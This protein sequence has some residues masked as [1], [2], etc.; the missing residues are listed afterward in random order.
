MGGWCRGII[1]YLTRHRRDTLPPLPLVDCL[2][3]FKPKDILQILYR[4]IC[5][6]TQRF[7][8]F[9]GFLIY[10]KSHSDNH[11]QIVML[12]VVIFTVSGSY[13]VILYN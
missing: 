6:F 3:S 1:Q 10:L 12:C 5:R 9:S 2:R 11:L 4:E 7:N 8:I 13:K